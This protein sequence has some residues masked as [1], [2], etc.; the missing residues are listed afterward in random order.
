MMNSCSIIILYKYLDSNG[1]FSRVLDMTV[2]I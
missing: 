2:L 1:R